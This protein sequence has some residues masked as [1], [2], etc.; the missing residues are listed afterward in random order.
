MAFKGG[1][2]SFF[3]SKG[4]KR[5]LK[6]RME[7]QKKKTNMGAPQKL[8]HSK[9]LIIKMC[10]VREQFLLVLTFTFMYLT[11]FDYIFILYMCIILYIY[12]YIYIY[13]IFL[14]FSVQTYLPKKWE[15]DPKFTMKHYALYPS[16]S[17]YKSYC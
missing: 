12:F 5:P 17:R 10:D 4:R 16:T 6:K 2:H 3:T 1:F 8:I 7:L 15:V 14:I 13:I 11:L 9:D